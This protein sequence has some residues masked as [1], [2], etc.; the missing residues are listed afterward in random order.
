M[1]YTSRPSAS[2]SFMMSYEAFCAFIRESKVQVNPPVLVIDA[3]DMN[4]RDMMCLAINAIN[5]TFLV[6]SERVVMRQ[7]LRDA[8]CCMDT[9]PSDAENRI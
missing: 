2:D 7:Q 3:L 8:A 1:V 6:E 4:E 9:S 5:F